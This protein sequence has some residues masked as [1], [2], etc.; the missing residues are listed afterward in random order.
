MELALLF[1]FIRT[2]IPF[3]EPNTNEKLMLYSKVKNP[4]NP[5]NYELLYSERVYNDYNMIS[6]RK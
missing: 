6:I 3:L 4:R 5:S 2:D 1:Y